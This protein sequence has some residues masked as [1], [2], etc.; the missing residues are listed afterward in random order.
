MG[1]FKPLPSRTTC[2]AFN[3]LNRFRSASRRS[4]QTRDRAKKKKRSQ[5]EKAAELLRLIDLALRR[6][7]L[8]EQLRATREAR[9]DSRCRRTADREMQ[10][11]GNEK[12]STSQSVSLGSVWNS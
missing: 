8:R 12:T 9:R 5:T 7:T 3:F 6:T 2:A 1:V 4:K 11:F 10:R